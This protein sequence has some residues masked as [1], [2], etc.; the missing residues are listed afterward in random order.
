[1][2]ASEVRKNEASEPAERNE[3]GT[4]TKRNTGKKTLAATP[5]KAR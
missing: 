4:S 1:M 3:R 5:G 2:A